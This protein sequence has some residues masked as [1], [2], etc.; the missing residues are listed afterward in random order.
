MLYYVLQFLPTVL[1]ATPVMIWMTMNLRTARAWRWMLVPIALA[2]LLGAGAVLAAFIPG[3]T[4][5]GWSASRLCHAISWVN[6]EP[7]YPGDNPSHAVLVRMYGPVSAFVYLPT[8]LAWRPTVA[9]LAGAG[10]N[11]VLLVAPTIWLMRRGNRLIGPSE[12][13]STLAGT[14]LLA[15]SVAACV[16]I[17]LP[18][19]ASVTIDAPAIG[20][21]ICACAVLAGR[22]ADSI[23]WRTGLLCGIFAALSIWTKQTMAPIVLA[24]GIYLLLLERIRAT[25]VMLASIAVISGLLL[26]AFNPRNMLFDMVTIPSRH[27]THWPWMDQFSVVLRGMRMIRR[28]V[29]A[30]CWML[31]LAIALRLFDRP[32]ALKLEALRDW[33]QRNGG[34]LLPLLVSLLVLPTTAMAYVKYGGGINNAAPSGYFA[35]VAAVMALL[36]TCAA[37][38]DT[39]T[40]PVPARL[41]RLA[42][43][44]VIVI[45]PLIH[46]REMLHTLEGL[47]TWSKLSDN[48]SEIAFRYSRQYPGEFYFPQC[49][50]G[51]LMGEGKAYHFDM[52]ILDRELAGMTISAEQLHAGIPEHMR[53]MFYHDLSPS[54]PVPKLLP[55]FDQLTH[56]PE[57]PGWSMLSAPDSGQ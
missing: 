34:W 46:H 17:L 31:L 14:A 52:A 20:F 1:L 23:S 28:D 32:R 22:S 49:P 12:W 57:L 5:D 30:V 55:Q 56:P 11:L 2:A 24:L 9:L 13:A 41:G 42:M 54:G 48:D 16:F 45:V 15:I 53:A 38:S 27:P 50:L 6:G 25:L 40:L 29:S 43:L 7:L 21:G 26:L 10:I 33:L 35:L 8:A 19:A 3:V 39:P 51:A 4:R 18:T 47:K 36:G 37:G 44:L